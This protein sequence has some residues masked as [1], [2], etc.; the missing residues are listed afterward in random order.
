MSRILVIGG[1]GFIGSH[2]TAAC[3]KAGHET[4]YTYATRQ[5]PLE[6]KV[7][8]IALEREDKRLVECLQDF[9]PEV[10]Y[11]SAVPPFVYSAGHDLQQQISVEGVRRTLAELKRVNPKALFVYLSTNTVF[12][13]GRGLYREEETPDPELRHDP[14]RVY[15][16]TKAAGEQS[17]LKNWPNTIV[18]RTSV[19]DG[20]DLS[21]ALY[22][23]L[24]KMVEQL[25]AGQTLLRFR[26]RFISPTLVNN[27][28]E[29]L[30]EVANS[31]FT[32]RGVLHLAGSE[33]VT[34]FQYGRYLARQLGLSEELIQAESMA[35]SPAMANSPSDHSLDVSF[36]QSLLHIKLLGVKEQLACIFD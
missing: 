5:V 12:G 29:A 6:A 32:Y 26:D 10:I 11:Y 33:R 24:Q 20:R 27:L 22:P 25:Q 28:V 2:L 18:A 1:S 16:I 8:Q 31:E 13:N 35:N 7:Y 3:L 34:D 9:R 14:Y 4:A 19:V 23:R 30:L 17:S 36:S 15:A 21:G